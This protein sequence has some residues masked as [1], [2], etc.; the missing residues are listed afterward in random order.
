MSN[1]VLENL[2]MQLVT[3][4]LTDMALEQAEQG[5]SGSFVSLAIGLL[6]EADVECKEAFVNQDNDGQFQLF[7]NS[8]VRNESF[9]YSFP[10]DA[11]ISNY[12]MA[13]QSALAE[14]SLEIQFKNL[15]GKNAA[16]A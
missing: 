12:T 1:K 11:E 5:R 4:G 14:L 15:G 9:E 3:S 7:F 2:N 13:I 6:M 10:L 8:K 16:S